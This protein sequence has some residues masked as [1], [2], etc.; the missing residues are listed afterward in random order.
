MDW[1]F[2]L[3]LVGLIALVWLIRL[4]VL[5][6][7]K[8]LPLGIGLFGIVVQG[9]AGGGLPRMAVLALLTLAVLP[10]GLIVAFLMGVND[11]APDGPGHPPRH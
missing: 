6:I 9:Y 8:G 5:V 10:I 11:L 7:R 2:I 1:T 4:V 3:V